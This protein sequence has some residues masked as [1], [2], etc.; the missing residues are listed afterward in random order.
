MTFAVFA[1]VQ[2]VEDLFQTCVVRMQNNMV[3]FLTEI[4]PNASYLIPKKPTWKLPKISFNDPELKIVDE[5][6]YLGIVVNSSLCDDSDVKHQTKSLYCVANKL[7][8]R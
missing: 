1:S 3:L 8:F 2:K 6:K 5:I 4:K 7:R